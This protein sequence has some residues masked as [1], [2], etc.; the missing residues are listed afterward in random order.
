MTKEGK[1]QLKNHYYLAVGANPKMRRSH[2]GDFPGRNLGEL[3]QDKL[4]P[5]HLRC[6]V[7]NRALGPVVRIIVVRNGVNANV[8][9]L[10]VQFL[11]KKI[12]CTDCHLE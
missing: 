11:R 10:A 3:F 9:T 2:S 1:S 8:V 5:N 6:P 7:L 4:V 12:S